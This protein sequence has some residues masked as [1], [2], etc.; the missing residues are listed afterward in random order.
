MPKA[1]LKTGNARKAR[2]K[3][4]K[5]P[6]AVPVSEIHGLSKLGAATPYRFDSPDGS[7]LEA[8]PNRYPGRDYV[9]TLEHHEFTSLCPMTG[10]PDFGV[11]RLRYAPGENCLESK[12]FKLYLSA[13]RNHGVFMESLTN[14]IAED[15][16]ALL[17][18]RRLT[19][20]GIFNVRGG[21]A[22]SVRVE[23]LAAG[24]SQKAG[25]ELLRLW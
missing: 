6:K 21:I 23:H 3:N 17:K 24:L 14:R 1:A 18:P 25:A 9:I 5:A 13:F 11:I 4:Q 10:Q 8:F 20:E 19:L 16:I 22:I 12:S 7:I 15:L 2:S